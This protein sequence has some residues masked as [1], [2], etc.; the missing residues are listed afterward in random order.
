[1]TNPPPHTPAERLAAMLLQL[2]QAVVLMRAGERLSQLLVSLITDKIRHLKQGFARL[3]ARIEAGTYKPRR[4]AKRRPPASRKPRTKS[5]LPYKFGWL[6]PMFPDGNGYRNWL[7]TLLRDPE[8]VALMAAAPASAARL[9]RPLCWMLRVEPPEIL[10]LPPRPRRVRDKPPKPPKP[11]PKPEG[12]W[13]H[14]PRR[15][16]K[17]GFYIGPPPE[18][19]SI[20]GPPRRKPA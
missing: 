12:K 15:R 9:I 3:A 13:P 6:V 18:F 14:D 8:M 16:D 17:Y 4:F 5:P 19:S 2:S 1:M 10:A 20:R 7:E 11:P